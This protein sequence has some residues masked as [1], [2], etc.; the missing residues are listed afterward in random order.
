[1]TVYG[2]PRGS[3]MVDGS[4]KGK[5]TPNTVDVEQGRHETQV[6]YEDGEVSEKKIVR[7]RKGSR[8]KLFFRQRKKK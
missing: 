1:M 5:Q 2:K 4:D 7:V 8:I 6:K 3:I